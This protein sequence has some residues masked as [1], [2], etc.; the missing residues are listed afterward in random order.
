MKLNDSQQRTSNPLTSRQLFEISQ[1]ISNSFNHQISSDSSELVILPVDPYHL[2]A[3]WHLD[4]QQ[5][6]NAKTD[7]NQ[8]LLL[9]I[10]WQSEQDRRQD[11]SKLWFNVDL[12]ATQNQQK[13]R[14]PVDASHYSAIIGILD[15]NQCWNSLAHSNTIH[16][17]AASMQPKIQKMQSAQ[18]NNVKPTNAANNKKSAELATN[19][20]HD[21]VLI[22]TK[23]KQIVLKQYAIND[24]DGLF[25]TEAFTTGSDN[26]IQS[27]K[28]YDEN[29]IDTL[30]QQTLHTKDLIS[31]IE[32]NTFSLKSHFAASNFS[33]QNFHL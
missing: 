33:G 8:Q 31:K 32:N 15:E 1:K 26:T 23:I 6:I 28:D 22:D 21:E 24:A 27:E 14:L 30:I 9:K 3:Y 16:I 19:P 17:P 29:L 11:Q 13:I 2:Y 5:L 25:G 7:S 18:T 20:I 10:N 12:D 4:N